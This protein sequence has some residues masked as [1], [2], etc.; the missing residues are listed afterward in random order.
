MENNHIILRPIGIIHSPFP[1][2]LDVPIQPSAA[3]DI[4]GKI[5]VFKDYIDCLADLD[6]FSTIILI[7]YF[8]KANKWKSKVK[9]YMD[10][11]EHGIFATRAPSR[12]NA[13]GLSVVEL[14]KIIKNEIIFYGADIIDGTPLLDIK[15]YVPQFDLAKP[16][17][18]KIGW[19]EDKIHKLQHTVDDGRFS[20]SKK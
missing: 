5:V 4:E 12:P 19:L 8:H 20:D 10:G 1:T 7:Y 11:R 17:I 14:K 18:T 6:G 15:P 13:I 3:K 2:T 16:N 9:P